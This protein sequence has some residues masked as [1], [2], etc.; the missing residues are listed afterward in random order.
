LM[1]RVDAYITPAQY[2]DVL[3]RCEK[4][5]FDGRTIADAL[6]QLQTI[7]PSIEAKTGVVYQRHESAV[8]K[9]KQLVVDAK[10]RVFDSWLDDVRRLFGD[11]ES[12]SEL[13]ANLVLELIETDAAV[14]AFDEQHGVPVQWKDGSPLIGWLK[15]MLPLFHST[16]ERQL[17]TL[18][19]SEGDDDN[20]VEEREYVLVC[21]EEVCQAIMKF[22]DQFKDVVQ[23]LRSLGSK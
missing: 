11:A 19:V 13:L 14:A 15:E 2:R 6:K 3:A 12:T 4:V 23:Q 20:N 17:K 10:E 22:E 5:P 21:I 18:T 16:A 7:L 8:E 1:A 9:L